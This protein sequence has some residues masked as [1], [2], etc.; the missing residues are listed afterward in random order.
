MEKGN[1]KV[2]SGLRGTAL[3]DTPVD[4]LKEVPCPTVM[5]KTAFRKRFLSMHLTK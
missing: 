1:G 4:R 5:H 3:A 2:D